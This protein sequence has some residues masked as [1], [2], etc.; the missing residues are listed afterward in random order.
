MKRLYIL[1]A[2]VSFAVPLHALSARAEDAPALTAPATPAPAA[3]AAEPAAP[4]ETPAAAAPATP[5]AETPTAEKPAAEAPAATDSVKPAETPATPAPAAPPASS[6]KY[7]LRYKFRQGETIRWQVVHRAKV[8]TTVSGTTQV[9]ETTSSSVKVWQVTSVNPQGQATFSHSV[10]SVDMRQQVS[11]REELRYNSLTDPKAPVGFE[12][13]AKAVNVILSVITLDP[14]GNIVRR[15][16]KHPQAAQTAASQI[17]VALPTEA[18]PVGHTWSQPHDIDVSLP[19]GIIKKIKTRQVF[20]LVSVNQGVAVIGIDTQM[21]T[22]IHDPA[23]EAQLVQRETA[24]QL[25]FD[26][27]AGRIIGQQMDLDKHVLGFSGAASSMHYVTRFTEELLPE[28]Q[29]A[30]RKP[31]GPA[32]PPAMARKPTPKPKPAAAAKRPT[33]R[34]GNRVR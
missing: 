15:E 10:A 34:S 5:P 3:P 11:G 4:M 31:A 29:A 32:P 23:I 24:G 19:T 9:A 17:T 27:A 14:Q 26:I 6:E 20:S 13:A 25:R 16:D 12:D 28:S 33:S 21:L 30:A 7:T 8:S 18:I 1:L 22:P 2:V